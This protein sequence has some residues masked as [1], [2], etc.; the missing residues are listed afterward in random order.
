M[1]A[2]K[3]SLPKITSP[4]VWLE[5]NEA[6]G[7]TLTDKG[8]GALFTVVDGSGTAWSANAGYFKGSNASANYLWTDNAQVQSIFDVFNNAQNGVGGQVLFISMKL[9]TTTLSG[10][11]LTFG[12]TNGASNGYQILH[13]GGNISMFITN[14]SGVRKLIN[15]SAM[16]TSGEHHLALMLD[17]KNGEYRAWIDGSLSFAPAADR[18]NVLAE[19]DNLEPADGTVGITIMSRNTATTGGS[20]TP[21]SSYDGAIKQFFAANLSNVEN[22]WR[23]ADLIV[24]DLNSVNKFPASLENW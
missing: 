3:K 12:S 14:G 4:Y 2:V 11:L 16:P 19:A 18:A 1:L 20:R 23:C 13:A 17:F 15:T 6:G 8:T 24:K 7:L 9:I 21:S 22:P 10:T 5:L